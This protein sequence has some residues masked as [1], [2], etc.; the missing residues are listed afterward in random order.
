[1]VTS[2]HRAVYVLVCESVHTHGAGYYT[3]VCSYSVMSCL[4]DHVRTDSPWQT[5]HAINARWNY[6]LRNNGP[7]SFGSTVRDRRCVPLVR[8]VRGG[9]WGT[10]GTKELPFYRPTPSVARFVSDNW[11]SCLLNALATIHRRPWNV[12]YTYS[13]S[14]TPPPCYFYRGT[15]SR[16]PSSVGILS[17]PLKTSSFFCLDQLGSQVILV[18]FNPDGLYPISRET[19]SWERYLGWPRRALSP[20]KV[21]GRSYNARRL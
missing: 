6:E 17:K 7:K 9:L 5:R 2:I 20:C 19:P 4:A 18:F 16:C 15:I 3:G 10:N 21:W 12:W 1:M 14:R 13:V 11:V 8:C